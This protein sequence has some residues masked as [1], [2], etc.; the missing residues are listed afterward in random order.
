MMYFNN[1]VLKI[2][3]LQVRKCDSASCFMVTMYSLLPFRLVEELDPGLS[4]GLQHVGQTDLIIPLQKMQDR[5]DGKWLYWSGGDI[6]GDTRLKTELD[7]GSVLL[8]KHLNAFS[9]AS[10]SSN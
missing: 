7:V 3:K 6:S 8:Q 5:L 2:R 10:V 1:L 9:L 4:G